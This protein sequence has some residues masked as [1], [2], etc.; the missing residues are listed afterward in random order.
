M[1]NL[2]KTKIIL[3]SIVVA[4]TASLLYFKT[5]LHSDALFLEA[6]STDLFSHGGRWADWKFSAAPAYLPDMLL[7]FL[8]YPIFQDA[9]WRIFFV[10]A[11][12][13]FMLTI[14]ATWVSKQICPKLSKNA[15]SIVILMVAFV[16]LVSAQS[17]MWLY[18]YTTNNHFAS[19]VFS[20]LCLGLFIR[21]FEK[22]TLVTAAILVLIGGAAKA[23]TAIYLISFTAPAFVFFL[24]A[25]II[26][27]NTIENYRLYRSRL[28]GMLAILIA[29]HILSVLFEE[30]LT[31]NSPLEGRAPASLEAAGNSLKLFLQATANAFSFDNRSTL[32]FT[33]AVVVSF[34][35][36]LYRMLRGIKLDGNSLSISLYSP[37][38]N[39]VD[40]KFVASVSFLAIVV[41]VNIA[42]AVLSGGFADNA[43]YRYFMFPIALAIIL[44]VILLDRSSRKISI[45]WNICYF[46]LIALIL[47]LSF[48]FIKKSIKSVNPVNS[49][50]TCLL[51]IENSGFVLKAGIADYWNARGV[52]AYLP[53]KNPIFATLNDLSPFFWVSTIGPIV[54]PSH[55]PEYKYNF[56]ILRNTG[57]GGNFNYTPDT[58]GKFLPVPSNIYSCP[59]S[60]TQVWLYSEG[61]LD[62]VMKASASAFL[63]KRNLADN[64]LILGAN[65]PGNT[66][67]KYGLGRIAKSFDNKAGFLSYGPYINLDGGHYKVVI[68]YAATGIPGSAIG[69]I[70]MGR[71][72]IPEG[73]VLHKEDI[74]SA[75]DGSVSVILDIP[76][77]GFP[78]FE[79]RTWFAG[80][81]E[82]TVHSLEIT[83]LSK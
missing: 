34:L 49:V 7:Y 62:L 66:G 11:A 56:A 67:E 19:L 33:I 2:E 80:Q 9:S 60:K 52:S 71:F 41:P 75:S 48:R 14:T 10:S 43:G 63:F 5:I 17:G 12:Q 35:F 4:L 23:S 72:N 53:K 45:I 42:G 37:S 74:L 8:A 59:D 47:V 21:F 58:I 57:N 40:W 32:L 18:F 69:Y 54:R 29:S 78:Q 26:L 36:L 64:L 76:P 44:S 30:L 24:S 46:I 51:D 15:I 70:D 16:T 13:V 20:L 65:L 28:I 61:D 55:Y 73:V 22:P 77:S 39:V 25:L 6:L 3:S 68:K 27:G 81:G 82:L 31:Y 79:A 38:T 1:I 83:K 50:A